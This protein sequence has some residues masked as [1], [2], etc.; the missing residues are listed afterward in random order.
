MHIQSLILTVALASTP[1]V[2]GVTVNDIVPPQT[3]LDIHPELHIDNGA[4]E[5][6]EQRISNP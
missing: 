4:D 3:F 1:V 2:P 5:W 6:I